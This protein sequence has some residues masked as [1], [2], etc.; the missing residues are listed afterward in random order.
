MVT[1]EIA[2]R[3]MDVAR[4]GVFGGRGWYEFKTSI[5][6]VFPHVLVERTHMPRP[7]EKI[8][9]GRGRPPKSY[10]KTPEGD[11]VSIE[12]TSL[13]W[14]GSPYEPYPRPHEASDYCSC[15]SGMY[16]IVKDKTICIFC[17]SSGTRDLI[18]NGS[19]H[20]ELPML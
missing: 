16:L 9:R 12:P 10:W 7:G 13:V 5:V 11:L 6:W 1:K 15:G 4:E 14:V 18:R 20:T 8:I 17:G 2:L 3:L 19:E